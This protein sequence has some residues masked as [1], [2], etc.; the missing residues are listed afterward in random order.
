M[1]K[2]ADTNDKIAI[3][4]TKGYKSVENTVVGGYQAVEKAVVG[5]YKK[6]ENGFVDTFLAKDGE[7][8]DE[9]KHRITSCMTEK[10]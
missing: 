7:T 9:A 2:I 1:S 5:G 6:I 3:A 8:V 4:V 10:D